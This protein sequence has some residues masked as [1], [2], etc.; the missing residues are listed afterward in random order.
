[1]YIVLK[2]VDAFRSVLNT[3]GEDIQTRLLCVCA[4]RGFCLSLL[5]FLFFGGGVLFRAALM[6]YG[7]SKARGQTRAVAATVLLASGQNPPPVKL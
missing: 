2:L 4:K 6:A 5:I 7:S 3:E 1:M